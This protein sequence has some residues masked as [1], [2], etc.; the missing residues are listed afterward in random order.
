[1]ISR[2]EKYDVL[3]W[4]PSNYILTLEADDTKTLAW[5]I[6]VEFAVHTDM[7]SHT[8]AVFTMGK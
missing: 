3:G 4:N 7:K 6:N 5:Y 1:M 2:V 8:G